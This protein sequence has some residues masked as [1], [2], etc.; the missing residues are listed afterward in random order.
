[1][2]ILNWLFIKRQQLIKTEANDASTDLVALGAEVPFTTRGDG[3]QTYARPLKDFS[4]AG[5]VANTAHYELDISAFPFT[6]NVT[7]TQ[8]IIDIINTDIGNGPKP[9]FASSYV[10]YLNNPNLDLSIANRDNV[11]IQY[12]V[13][14]SKAATLDNAIPYLVST[15]IVAS[16]IEF[17]LYNANPAAEAAEPNNQWEGALYVYYELY[18]I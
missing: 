9:A 7:T 10:F 2:D 3:Y 4:T 18:T 1:M 8:G 14:Y 5:D 17:N 15:G 6:V 16:G 11:Y 12:S 13:Y